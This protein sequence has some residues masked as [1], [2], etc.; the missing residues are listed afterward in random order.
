MSTAQSTED[1]LNTLQG[2]ILLGEDGKKWRY[3]NHTYYN[4]KDI[5]IRFVR[6]FGAVEERKTEKTTFKD[7]WYLLKKYPI[8]KGKEHGIIHQKHPLQMAEKTENNLKGL[9]KHLFDAIRKLEGGSMKN[10]DAKTMA[11]VAQV[12]INS[13]KLEMDFKKL[14]EDKS[15]VDLLL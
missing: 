3:Y 6:G 5:E 2:C 8:V 14:T 11:Q 7:L 15:G 9:R 10:E 1:I 13:A 4:D 12:I